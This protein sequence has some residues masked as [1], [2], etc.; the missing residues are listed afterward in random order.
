MDVCLV[1]FNKT[2]AHV[3]AALALIRR[4]DTGGEFSLLCSNTNP[5]FSGFLESDVREVEPKGLVGDRYVEY[6]V[7]FCGR[8]RVAL[9]WPGKEASLVGTY[10]HRFSD[11]GTEVLSTAPSEALEVLHNKAA[12][13]VQC[14]N[15]TL[16]PP[17]FEL[18]QT[19]SEFRQAYEQLRWRHAVLSIKPAVSVYGIGFRIIDEGRHALEHIL[20]GIDYHVTLK[21]L[22]SE[23]VRANEFKPLLLMEYLSG[24]EYSV[25]CLAYRGVLHCAIMRRKSLDPRKGQRIEVRQ[26]V[27]DACSELAHR[28]QLNG[29]FNAQF[30]ESATG[31]LRILEI[32]PR[33]SG[34]IAMSC[35]A[36]PNLPYMAV[37]SALFGPERIKIGPIQDGVRVG[38]VEQAVVLP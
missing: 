1:W 20:G 9:F 16:P 22:S 30:R 25:D 7:E 32:N 19:A 17:E 5:H 8:H 31:Q 28:Y 12:F 15:L 26:D 27:F 37:A 14:Q 34:G 35:L 13:Y 18:V 24:H 2:F 29:I 11:V 36:G 6:C 21:E 33:M 23:L 4:D 10:A 3:R 38:E